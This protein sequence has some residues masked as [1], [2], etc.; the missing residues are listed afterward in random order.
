MRYV[1]CA[2]SV[3]LLCSC[4]TAPSMRTSFGG[5]PVAGDPA[6]ANDPRLRHRE[7][8]LD[9]EETPAWMRVAPRNNE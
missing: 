3:V 7:F 4:A 1:L 9:R 5:S 8:Y 2:V 6:S